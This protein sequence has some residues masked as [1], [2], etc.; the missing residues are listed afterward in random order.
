MLAFLMVLAC[1]GYSTAQRVVRSFD[2]DQG[3]GL[4]A[5]ASNPQCGRQPEMSV[6]ANGRWVV[7]VTR[8]NVLIY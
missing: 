4:S 2:G 6:A 5:C 1:F 3:V 8:Q 7:Q